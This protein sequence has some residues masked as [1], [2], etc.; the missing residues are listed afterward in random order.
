MFNMEKILFYYFIII[1]YLNILFDFL[2]LYKILYLR[3]CIIVSSQ[4]LNIYFISEESFYLQEN[5]D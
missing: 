2:R 3:V 1:K 5:T 4:N